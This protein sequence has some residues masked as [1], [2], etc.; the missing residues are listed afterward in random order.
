M[1]TTESTSLNLRLEAI[2][3]AGPRIKM[4]RFAAAR[5]EALP[6]ASPGAHLDIEVAPG[7]LRQYSLV[8]IDP[9]GTCY[10]IAVL[11]QQEGRGGSMALHDQAKIGAIYKASAP[12]N[13]FPLSATPGESVL[14]GGG[15]GITPLLPMY[16]AL[17]AR[18]ETPKLFYWARTAEDF[19]CREELAQDPAVHL[20]VTTSPS[21]PRLTDLIPQFPAG[22][23]LYCCGPEAMLNAF[24]D[25]TTG[26][27]AALLHIERFAP[28]V[29]AAAEVNKPFTVVLRRSERTLEIPANKSILEVCLDEGIDAEYSCEEGVCGACQ[30]TV[31]EGE[32]AHRDSVAPAVAHDREHTM[33]ICCSRA[34]RST[35]V[36]DL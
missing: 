20:L 13:N 5:G 16:R 34:A 24:T 27:P 17:K 18:G 19:L 7:L 10:T 8:E 9:A 29:P 4:F 25:A 3:P 12:R 14:F 21:V 31:L 2:T 28:T 22:A 15:I 26:R 23:H 11:R 1:A 32:V 33:T 6:S 36:L 35:L 30:V